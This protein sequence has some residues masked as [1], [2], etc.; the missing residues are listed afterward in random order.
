MDTISRDQTHTSLLSQCNTLTIDV[1]CLTVALLNKNR[2]PY[3]RVYFFLGIRHARATCFC[4][5]HCTTQT[6]HV[7]KGEM[8]TLWQAERHF[9]HIRFTGAATILLFGHSMFTSL[10]SIGSAVGKR[11]IE[12]VIATSEW[13]TE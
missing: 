6:I 13:P 5:S 11:P 1:N 4:S 2:H 12:H 8:L 10:D 7:W 3:T 9:C